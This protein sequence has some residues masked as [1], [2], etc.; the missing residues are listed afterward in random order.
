M[1]EK[2]RSIK[3]SKKEEDR[4]L[5]NI[6]NAASGLPSST[7]MVPFQSSQSTLGNDLPN[8]EA[9]PPPLPSFLSNGMDSFPSNE[10][11]SLQSITYPSFPSTNGTNSL[12][13]SS[14]NASSAV[15][16]AKAPI[17]APPL[18]PLNVPSFP[19]SDVASLVPLNVPSVAS[20]STSVLK[21]PIPGEGTSLGST[22]LKDLKIVVG[23]GI[24]HDQTKVMIR[25][26]GGEV[27][28][29]LSKNTSAFT[30]DPHSLSFFLF[31]LTLTSSFSSGYFVVV[32][33]LSRRMFDRAQQH[34]VNILLLDTIIRYLSGHFKNG[35]LDH[36]QRVH[37]YQSN[38][39]HSLV[40]WSLSTACAQSKFEKNPALT[41][42]EL[43]VLPDS[44]ITSK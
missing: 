35:R 15:N 33:G 19:S 37:S 6:T 42:A 38:Y 8:L 44:A 25:N 26:F 12:M 10:M 5:A 18:L 43:A 7:A 23:P 22:V 4:I 40:E 14:L 31:F 11:N 36:L 1:D 21:E 24:N 41:E 29:N 20:A 2:G 9:P 28:T 16:A 13:D 27:M 39:N 30:N 34:K 17:V 3:R 32:Q